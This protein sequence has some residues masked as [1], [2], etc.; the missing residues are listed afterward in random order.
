MKRA[1]KPSSIVLPW[2]ERGARVGDWFSWLAVQRVLLVA[3]I[4]AIALGL[5]YAANESERRARTYGIVA[6]VHQTL[7]GFR[8]NYGR[9]PH[10]VR[11]LVDAHAQLGHRFREHPRDAWGNRL[12]IKCPGRYDPNGEDVISAGSSGSFL[13]D[14]NIP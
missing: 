3:V 9:C 5:I 12:W 1:R 4:A 10:N 2:E 8:R 13:D 14:D 11:E 6:E 7:A